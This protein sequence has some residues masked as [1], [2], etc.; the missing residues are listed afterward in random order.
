MKTELEI[1]KIALS[2][3]DSDQAEYVK[4]FIDGYK[5]E[6]DYAFK[7][8]D[9]AKIIGNISMHGFSIG[10]IVCL[11]KKNRVD[12]GFKSWYIEYKKGRGFWAR[13]EDM[14]KIEKRACI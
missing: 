12:E 8:G 10:E 4:G 2:K 6:N 11:S 3:L 7:A 13:E 5:H 14:I 1:L 9:Y